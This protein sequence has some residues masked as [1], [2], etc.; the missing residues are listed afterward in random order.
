MDIELFRKGYCCVTGEPLVN[1]E[2]I[3]IMVLPYVAT[4]AFP[5]SNNPLLYG[6]IRQA[7]A[8]VSD[9]QYM[10]ETSR[11]TARKLVK[12]AVELNREGMFIY[13]PISELEPFDE[14]ALSFA[15]S[16]VPGLENPVLQVAL[17]EILEI[18]NKHDLCGAIQI[19]KDGETAHTVRLHN[20]QSMLKFDGQ[21]IHIIEEAGAKFNE[22][23]P[24]LISLAETN[25]FVANVLAKAQVM[26]MDRYHKAK[27]ISN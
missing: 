16:N 11:A 2:K 4:W 25:E 1:A 6:E 22:T 24:M 27:G 9:A 12:H 5:T 15:G 14:S 7:I 23:F 3:N 10:S 13:H 20:S 19:T 8:I 21:Q 26:L 18:L 17:R